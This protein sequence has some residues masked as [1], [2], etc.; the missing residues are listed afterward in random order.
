LGPYFIGRYHIQAPAPERIAVAIPG[1]FPDGSLLFLSQQADQL[2]IAFFDVRKAFDD[3]FDLK[4]QGSEGMTFRRPQRLQDP[5]FRTGLGHK[6]GAMSADIVDEHRFEACR[7]RRI[8][9]LLRMI[10]G[11]GPQERGD[12]LRLQ[13]P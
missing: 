9:P 6:S 8:L 13:V 5:F 12:F 7:R 11:L 4:P 2:V 3:P 1:P 10:R